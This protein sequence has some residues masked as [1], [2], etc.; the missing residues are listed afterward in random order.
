MPEVT[1]CSICGNLMNVYAKVTVHYLDQS[2]HILNLC[3]FYNSEHK[4]F[5]VKHRG[6]IADMRREGEGNIKGISIESVGYHG[7]RFT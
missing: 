7:G 4:R 2:K 5:Q 6:L 3:V 1:K